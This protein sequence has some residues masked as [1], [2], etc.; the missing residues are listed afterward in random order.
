LVKVRFTVLSPWLTK[1][2]ESLPPDSPVKATLQGLKTVMKNNVFAFGNTFWLQQ[3]G[4]TMGTS[5]ACMAA[6]VC[7]SHHEEEE[8]VPPANN[9]T[10]V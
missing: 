9:G 4:T 7:C 5:V 3:K 1:H 2:N 6:A 10:P 8:T